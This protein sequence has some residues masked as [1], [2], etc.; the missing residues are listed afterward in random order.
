[1][2]EKDLGVINLH[3]FFTNSYNLKLK[4]SFFV[5]EC[6]IRK[7]YHSHDIHFHKKFRFHKS[8]SLISFYLT[9]IS[10]TFY[11]CSIFWN[12]C[13][14][15]GRFS[16]STEVSVWIRLPHFYLIKDFWYSV[17]LARPPT[18]FKKIL[19]GD[20]RDN[21][22]D[23]LQWKILLNL[24]SYSRGTLDYRWSGHHFWQDMHVL[25]ENMRM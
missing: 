10:E 22:S 20:F 25:G 24:K 21:F 2:R 4:I 16:Y 11:W 15:T 12:H 7:C 9:T 19:L 5:F 8:H 17:T 14:T 18:N 3:R 6:I 23:I 13:G 1:M